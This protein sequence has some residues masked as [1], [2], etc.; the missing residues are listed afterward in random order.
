M[1]GRLRVRRARFVPPWLARSR[2]ALAGA[3]LLA[4]L[5]IGVFIA[6][7]LVPLHATVIHRQYVL[8]PPSARFPFGTDQL[9]RDVLARVIAGVRVSLLVGVTAV[10]LGGVVGVGSGLLSGYVGGAVD[11][12]VMRLWDVLLA[13]P[14]ALLGIAAATA[15][16]PGTAS[17]IVAGALTGLPYF[18]R[19]A[20]AGAFVER[21]QEYV[22][23]A[24][25]LGARHAWILR[26]H[27][28]RNTLAPVLVQASNLIGQAI[29]LEAAL[30]YLGLGIQPPNPSLGTMLSEAQTFLGT[31]P[32]YP[33][34]PGVALLVLVIS[35]TFVAEGANTVVSRRP[36]SR[37]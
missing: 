27:I 25:S 28:L 4:A 16:G 17:V 37:G 8:V 31:A 36:G 3:G 5:G 1:P 24:R 21:E 35:V 12:V 19:L 14:G 7:L 2:M 32:W 10:L 20:R 13:F 30:S 23:A 26:R 11:A 9:G 22:L 15:I 34:F 29:L 33:M 18:S 6:P